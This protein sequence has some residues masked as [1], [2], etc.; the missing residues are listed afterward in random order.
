MQ[1]FFDGKG[2]QFAAVVTLIDA[3]SLCERLDH[4][5]AIDTIIQGA[6]TRLGR[7]GMT[8]VMTGVNVCRF[9]R[10]GL[11]QRSVFALP[12]WPPPCGENGHCSCIDLQPMQSRRSPV[13]FLDNRS[14]CCVS[15]ISNVPP[16]EIAKRSAILMG[17]VFWPR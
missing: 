17:L 9:H 15:G 4:I 8:H 16:I 6:Q 5:G 3:A 11:R 7:L 10:Y 13:T 2:T 12:P 1:I 14:R